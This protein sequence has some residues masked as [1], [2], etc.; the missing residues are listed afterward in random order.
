MKIIVIAGNEPNAM[1]EIINMNAGE[2][3]ASSTR[4]N[5]EEFCTYTDTEKKDWVYEDFRHQFKYVE[6]KIE[7]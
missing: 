1:E 3:L 7:E 2:Y 5:Y 4:L 6:I